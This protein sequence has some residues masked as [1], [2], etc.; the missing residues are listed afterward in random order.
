MKHYENLTGLF[1]NRLEQHR[2]SLKNV[3]P[4]E[5]YDPENYILG[6]GGKRLRP[7]LVLIACDLFNGLPECAL[8]S[9]MCV[10]LFHNF[11]LVH[12]D[13]LDEAPL[14][15]SQATVHSKW[16][17]NI[18]ILSGD[19]MLVKAFRLLEKYP[20]PE[21]KQLAKLFSQTAIEVCEGQQLDMNFEN[22]TSVSA[23]DYL[24]MITRKTAV[25]LGC[26][27]QMGAINSGAAKKD[28]ENIYEFGRHLGI[29]F[30]LLDDLLDAYGNTSEFGKVS[31]GDIVANKKTYLL[32]KALETGNEWQ[33]AELKRLMQLGKEHAE[34]KIKGVKN[35]Y[36]DLNISNICRQK[37]DEHTQI[38][39]NHLAT[40]AADETKKNNLKQFAAGLLNRT[41]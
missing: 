33:Q 26:S 30:Q 41:L 16:N 4:R 11:S 6:I 10:E 36:N 24:N 39:I 34:E 25:L 23:E 14:R 12:D 31:G 7:L 32:I 29:A 35:L 3:E 15:R 38:A 8:D 21:F 18:A 9:A 20:D 13:I 28:Q 17:T 27:L 19:V 2:E 40:I 22:Q 5:L 1:L 37:A